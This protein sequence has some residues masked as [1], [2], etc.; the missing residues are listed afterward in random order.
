MDIEK[1]ENELKGLESELA[2]TKKELSVLNSDY[3]KLASS[4]KSFTD[5]ELNKMKKYNSSKKDYE[6]KILNL[7]SRIEYLKNKIKEAK[8][9]QKELDKLNKKQEKLDARQ[10]KLESEQKEINNKRRE[11]KKHEKGDKTAVAI[12]AFGISAMAIVV[13]ATTLCAAPLAC[14]MLAEAIE[15]KKKNANRNGNSCSVVEVTNTPAPLIKDVN[16][17][18][19]ELVTVPTPTAEPTP[20]PVLV[21]ITN[22]DDVRAAAQRVYNDIAPM[23]AS[24]NDIVLN[25]NASHENIEDMIRVLNGEMPINSKFDENTLN[26]MI[27]MNADIFANVGHV[28]NQLY[29]VKYEQLFEDNSLEA[30][31]ARSYEEIYVKIVDYRK[32]GNVDGFVEPVGVLGNKLYNEWYLAGLYGGFNPYAL[33]ENKQ[34]LA[35]LAST[36]RISNYVSEYIEDI[37]MHEDP[38]FTI[39]IPTCYNENGEQEYRSF[40]E[41]ELGLYTGKSF[42]GEVIC[43]RDNQMFIPAAYAYNNLNNAL[44]VKSEAQVKSLK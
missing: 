43:K 35:F 25:Y 39:C 13:L 34:Y 4:K 6:T 41:I 23:L 37:R 16:G 38:N 28:D 44:L 29:K 30:L 15:N 20:V 33:P 8:G 18:D 32:E 26:Q 42:D 1:L 14:T 40:E 2:T 7:K 21:D 24:E 22:E 27:Q 11:I 36:S 5:E 17:K 12:T 19:V 10:E 3:E 9:N 31:Y